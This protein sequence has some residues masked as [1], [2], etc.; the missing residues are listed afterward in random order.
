[1]PAGA[2]AERKNEKKRP[3]GKKDARSDRRTRPRRR[4]SA[5]A[6]AGHGADQDEVVAIA[7]FLSLRRYLFLDLY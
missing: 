2:G 1:M 6:L 7:L 3:L 4:T 5:H